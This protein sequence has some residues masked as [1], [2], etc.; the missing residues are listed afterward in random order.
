MVGVPACGATAPLDV[1]DLVNE[2]K[3][4]IGVVEGRS[5]PPEFLPRLAAMMGGGRLPVGELI[6]TFPLRDIERAAEE[7]RTGLAVKP[8]LA[9]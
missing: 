8:V 9:P 2:S 3:R 4:V 5:N 6:K 7:M 1:A